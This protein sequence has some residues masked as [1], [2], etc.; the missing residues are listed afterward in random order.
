[1]SASLNKSFL[2][3]NL[4]RDPELKY[5]PQ[6]TAVCNFSLAVSRKFKQGE[7][8]KTQTIFPRIVVWGKIAEACAKYLAKGSS[9]LVVGRLDSRQYEAD[10]RKVTVWE[11][12]AEEVQ[13]LSKPRDKTDPAPNQD[14]NTFPGNTGGDEPP[15]DGD[16]APF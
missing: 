10:G 6:G 3:G 11:V 7:E 4:T 12:V 13:F 5:T 15:P 1:M 14:T 9:A 8:W 16:G 2:V